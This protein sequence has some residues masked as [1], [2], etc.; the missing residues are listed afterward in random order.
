MIN[1]LPEYRLSSVAR[2]LRWLLTSKPLLASDGREDIIMDGYSS[3]RL[4]NLEHQLG[5]WNKHGRWLEHILKGDHPLLGRY[6]ERLISWWIRMSKRYEERG[7]GLQVYQGK[8]TIGEMDFLVY[9]RRDDYFEHWEV[10]VKFYLGYGDRGKLANW[11]G[12]NPHDRL[13]RKYKKLMEHQLPLSGRRIS[14]R[15]LEQKG[16]DPARL[17]RRLLFKGHLFQ[18][19]D[20]SDRNLPSEINPEM[21]L[22]W[23]CYA[24]ELDN[25]LSN[26]SPAHWMAVERLDWMRPALIKH[27]TQ[28]EPSDSFRDRII[29]KVRERRYAELVVGLEPAREGKGWIETERGFVVPDHWP[30]GQVD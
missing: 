17:R 20:A 13:D 1:K 23:W 12:P 11:I 8:R 3:A 26:R 19:Y 5:A 25:L 7:S 29:R 18:P 24:G 30:D 14:R 4:Q 27:D 28:P 10:A 21:G 9:D 6:V 2:D 16:V 15:I 22:N